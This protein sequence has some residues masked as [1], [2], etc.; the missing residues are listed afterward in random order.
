[1][2]GS[3]RTGTQSIERAILLLRE[4]A[5]HGKFGWGLWE[6]AERCGLDRGTTH[7]ILACLVRER[8]LLQRRSNRHYVPG[9]LIF[10]LGLA[11]ASHAE[12]QVA[13]RVAVARVAKRFGATSVLYLRSGID[14]VCSA[15][16]GPAVYGGTILKVGSRR[17]LM[18]SVG[19]AAILM[20]LPP[21]EARAIVTKNKLQ[22]RRQMR[23]QKRR[24]GGTSIRLFENMLR[25][26]ET[27]GYAFNQGEVSKGVHSW[28]VPI[29]NA[30]GVVFSSLT[31]AGRAADFPASRGRDLV[32]GLREEVT[33]IEREARRVLS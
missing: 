2:A 17:P 12:F 7:R 5:T 11:D 29:R 13:C 19:G 25:R 6:I 26:S 1:M 28:G 33:R 21:Q 23:Q 16:A 30:E 3:Q 27:L 31:V 15:R 4:I 32:E 24:K 22:L 9:P 20:A 10:E 18:S 8:L 14:W